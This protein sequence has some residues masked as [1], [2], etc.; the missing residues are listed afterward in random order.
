ML[1]IKNIISSPSSSSES[2]HSSKNVEDVVR[3]IDRTAIKTCVIGISK[4]LW[5][6]EIITHSALFLSNKEV[7][8]FSKGNEIEGII[9]EYGRYDPNKKEKENIK[10][11][12]VIYRYGQDFGGLRYYVN[13]FEEFKRIHGNVVYIALEISKYNQISF[14][15]LIDKI[16]PKCE[17]KWAKDKYH[18]I[19]FNCRTFVAQALNEIKAIYDS[20]YIMKGEKTEGNSKEGE[21]YVPKEIIKVLKKFE[22]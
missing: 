20:G 13:N 19:D 2:L 22:N 5:S 17:F 18:F 15:Y 21:N 3:S 11:G 8:K 1:S 7:T 14:S 16:A 10:N 9:L 4:I 12:Y 6:K